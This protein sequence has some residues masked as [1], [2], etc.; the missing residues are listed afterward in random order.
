ME[1]SDRA[2]FSVY[3]RAPLFYETF[4]S[5]QTSCSVNKRGR[6]CQQLPMSSSLKKVPNE[7]QIWLK[8]K[9]HPLPCKLTAHHFS[10]G[11]LCD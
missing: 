10:H 2:I 5:K 7:N 8:I 9:Y 3:C 4:Y 1:E 6:F 11:I